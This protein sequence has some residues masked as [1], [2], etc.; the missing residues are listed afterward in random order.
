[1]FPRRVQAAVYVQPVPG[2]EDASWNASVAA[3]CVKLSGKRTVGDDCILNIA[4]TPVSASITVCAD[5]RDRKNDDGYSMCIVLFYLLTA[6]RPH[7]RLYSAERFSD[8]ERDI[9]N[10]DQQSCG[11]EGSG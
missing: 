7:H 11:T 1:M 2:T 4:R 9:Y 5:A 8:H 6:H 3:F 10:H